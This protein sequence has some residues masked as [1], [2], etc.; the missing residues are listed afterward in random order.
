MVQWRLVQ[1]LKQQAWPEL[2]TELNNLPE[3]YKKSL[4]WQYWRAKAL[5]AT[6]QVVNGK[7]SLKAFI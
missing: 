6:G 1:L 7:E 4:Q 2:I 5:I 3:R